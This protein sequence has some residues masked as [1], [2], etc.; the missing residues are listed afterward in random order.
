[1]TYRELASLIISEFNQEQLDQDVTIYVKGVDEFYGEVY[2][3]K[4]PI[5]GQILDPNHYYL[6]I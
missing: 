1:M 6:A 3:D 5:D 4:T 2:L